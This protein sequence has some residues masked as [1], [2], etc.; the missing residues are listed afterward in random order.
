[1]QR[2]LLWAIILPAVLAA[3]PTAMVADEAPRAA[4]RV[5]EPPFRPPQTWTYEP[6]ALTVKVGSTVTWTNSG[7]V[8]H[9]LTADDRKSFDS[10]MI[11]PKASFSLTPRSPGTFAYHCI[12]HPWMKGT[13]TVEP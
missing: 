12:Y 1:M 7:A 8:I 10:G 2:L 4:V 9:T 6:S 3:D 5:V 11:R 13:L